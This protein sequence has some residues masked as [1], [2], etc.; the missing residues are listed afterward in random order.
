MGSR[1]R[2]GRR[3]EADCQARAETTSHGSVKEKNPFTSKPLYLVGFPR[4]PWVYGKD[5]SSAQRTLVSAWASSTASLQ[6]RKRKTICG[7]TCSPT[8][9]SATSLNCVSSPKSPHEEGSQL[10]HSEVAQVPPVLE[11]DAAAQRSEDSAGVRGVQVEALQ[12][13]AGQRGGREIIR[14]RS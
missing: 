12:S 14:R 8:V 11:G 10:T 4:H 1:R 13:G 9:P 7:V 6:R 3:L 5:D 2:P